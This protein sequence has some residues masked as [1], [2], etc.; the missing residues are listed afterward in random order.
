MCRLGGG[1]GGGGGGGEIRNLRN[2]VGCE[3]FAI[4]QNSTISLFLLL[5]APVSLHFLLFF[6]SDL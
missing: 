2:Y 1:G 6:P 3:I 5:Y 4:L